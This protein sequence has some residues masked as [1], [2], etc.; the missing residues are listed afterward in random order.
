MT[1]L[2]PSTSAQGSAGRSMDE[3]HGLMSIK[4]LPLAEADQAAAQR[5][6]H[7]RRGKVPVLP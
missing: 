1:E 4:E 2:N 3:R 7:R 6:N 5:I